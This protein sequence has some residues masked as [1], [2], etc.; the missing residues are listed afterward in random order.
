MK[1]IAQLF[2]ILLLL[3]FEVLGIQAQKGLVVY[4]QDTLCFA[5][6]NILRILHEEPDK[7]LISIVYQDT[8]IVRSLEGIDSIGIERIPDCLIM[9]ENIGDWSDMRISKDGSVALTKMKDDD[10]PIEINMM[11]PN[12]SL[13]PI[14]SKIFFDENAYPVELNMNYCRCLF[15]WISDSMA[16]ITI[17]YSDSLSV[18]Y[19]SIQCQNEANTRPIRRRVPNID[20]KPWTTR[21]GGAIEMLGGLAGVGFGGVM[22]FGS[23]AAE[24]FSVGSS[25]PISTPGIA[26]GAYTIRGGIQSTYR[27][28]INAFT[29]NYETGWDPIRGTLTA[30]AATQSFEKGVVPLIPDKYFSYLVD[31]KY[32]P[33]DLIPFFAQL[34]GQAVS[35]IGRPFTWYDLVRAVQE[36][37][38]TGIVKDVTANSA[39]IR[40]YVGSYILESPNGRFDTEYGIVVYSSKDGKD[41]H[42]YNKGNEE[43]RAGGMIEHFF[44]DLKP[45][46]TYKYCTYYIDRTN[47]VSALGE[48]KTFTTD[49][50]FP[51]TL[52]DFKVTKSQY[53][54]GAFTHEGN[55]YDYRYD[56]SVTATLDEDAEGIADWGYVYLDPNGRE[57]FISLKQF[58]RS[59]TDERWAYF[60]NENPSTCTLYGYVEYVGS[61]ELVYGEPHDYPLKHTK[62]EPIITTGGYSNVTKNSAT[63]SCTYYNVPE[64][65]ICGVEFSSSEG[66]KEDSI[67]ATRDGEY[68]FALSS[69]KPNTIYTYRAFVIIDGEYFYA[70]ELKQFTT[71]GS[72]GGLI[73]CPDSNHPHWIDMGLPSGTQWRCC[74][75]GASAPEE[76]GGYYTFGQV[77]SAPTFDQIQELVNNCK[78][79]WTKQNDVRGGKFTGPNGGT[80]FLPA[81]GWVYE[82]FPAANV[83]SHGYYWSSTPNGEGSYKFGFYWERAYCASY[84]RWMY[85]SVRPVR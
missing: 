41:R 46:I 65:A 25:T 22:I 29:N 63:V 77:A 68:S 26:V 59:K 60:R 54:K 7:N 78:Y 53:K 28:F 48:E 6:S 76:Y 83:G 51:V 49:K 19:D 81:A 11:T 52:S 50:V 57:A 8:T 58:G 39:I 85:D 3:F 12:D 75:E 74:N 23:G 84:G 17:I 13:G 64:G 15:D 4:G 1:K 32:K 5:T 24:I 55:Q 71:E 40:G 82:G 56:V 31:S 21:I 67:R 80:I 36:N 45:G 42:I 70:K 35:N 69:L 30:Q 73:S 43:F 47:G 2:V 61:D 38:Y 66:E 18:K 33:N 72:G 20:E 16:N 37:V 44:N 34:L 27:G 14:F 10:T 79:E 62:K 9:K